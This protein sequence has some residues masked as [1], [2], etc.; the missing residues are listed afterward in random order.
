MKSE[1]GVQPHKAP[2][3]APVILLQSEFNKRQIPVFL[4][5]VLPVLYTGVLPVQ[6]DVPGQYSCVSDRSAI[7][8]LLCNTIPS[9][10]FLRKALFFHFP[11]SPFRV[12]GEA[13]PT[14]QL[15]GSQ[16]NFANRVDKY[17]WQ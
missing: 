1:P 5:Y 4:R 7:D 8:Y 16:E 10:R 6:F 11:D 2:D 15:K 3:F 9:G 12:I 13:D 17:T 14:G